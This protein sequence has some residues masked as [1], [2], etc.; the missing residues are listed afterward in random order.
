MATQ[1]IFKIAVIATFLFMVGATPARAGGC[2]SVR[3]EAPVIMPDG[4]V[5]SSGVLK[6]CDTHSYSPV[7]SLHKTYIDG[8]AVGM[9]RSRKFRSE[10]GDRAT[11]TFVFDRYAGGR[12][13]L[14]GYVMPGHDGRGSVTYQLA[15]SALSGPELLAAT[16][17]DSSGAA[18]DFGPASSTAVTRSIPRQVVVETVPSP[19]SGR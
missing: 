9:L 13:R 12:L 3:V 2:V 14:I 17:L 4:N 19:A 15:P 7:A 1:S 11:P 10:A 16:G 6:V 18:R 5:S 8:V